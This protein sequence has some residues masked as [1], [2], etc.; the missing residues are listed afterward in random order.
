MSFLIPWVSVSAGVADDVAILLQDAQTSGGLLLPASDPDRLVSEL[1]ARGVP[2]AVI[3][4][5]RAGDPGHIE[6]L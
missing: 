5:V 1:S 2:A 3:G 6:V 4:S